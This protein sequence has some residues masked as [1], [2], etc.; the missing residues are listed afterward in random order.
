MTWSWAFLTASHIAELPKALRSGP[1][2]RCSDEPIQGRHGGARGHESGK[3]RSVAQGHRMVEI[4]R[5]GVK[6]GTHG[7]KSGC[8]GEALTTR[9][10]GAREQTSFPQKP[11][12]R[13]RF[14]E[15][16]RQRGRA[17]RGPRAT[18][19]LHCCCHTFERQGGPTAQVRRPSRHHVTHSS[20]SLL[21]PVSSS[22]R[23]TAS[24]P[25]D[26]ASI[27]PVRPS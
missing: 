10:R 16:A 18:R 24:W 26:D 4:E 27:S 3:E 7:G 20:W 11:N 15:A 12:S 13:Q 23:T 6:S 8:W 19:P 17:R 1:V 2:G 21:A 9:C 5:T 25:P 22:S 14:S